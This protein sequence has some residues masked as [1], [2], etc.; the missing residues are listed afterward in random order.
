MN[1]FRGYNPLRDI[2]FSVFFILLIR[3]AFYLSTKRAHEAQT[4]QQEAFCVH[5]LDQT[6][7]ESFKAVKMQLNH[8]IAL[9]KEKNMNESIDQLEDM[10]ETLAV[11]ESQYSKNS[12]GLLFLGPLAS[13][14]IVLKEMALEKKLQKIT[15][16][17]N[18]F[19]KKVCDRKQSI[20]EKTSV[21]EHLK[22]NKALI[23]Q[24]IHA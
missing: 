6:V 21:A 20:E 14:Y 5:E 19:L 15:N 9:A 23:S 8:T 4:V 2:I 22:E 13:V 3:P 18:G 24:W 10:K 17:L 16:D 1:I 7:L 12:P 11:I